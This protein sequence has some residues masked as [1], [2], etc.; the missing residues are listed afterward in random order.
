MDPISSKP[1]LY[2]D[3]EINTSDEKKIY[4]PR[5]WL[6][7]ITPVFKEILTM[8]VIKT[9]QIRITLAYPLKTIHFLLACIT[10]GHLGDVHVKKILEENLTDNLTDNIANNADLGEIKNFLSLCYEYKVDHMKNLCDEVFSTDKYLESFD[11][12]S[13]INMCQIFNMTHIQKNLQK[14]ITKVDYLDYKTMPCS[15]LNFFKE[16]S[17]YSFVE[18]FNLWTIFNNPTDN[19]L[20]NAGL[21]KHNYQELPFCLVGGMLQVLKK[22]SKAHNYKFKILMDLSYVTHPK[23]YVITHPI[24]N[25][26]IGNEVLE[27]FKEKTTSQFSF[28]S[29]DSTKIAITITHDT[30]IYLVQI[31][32]PSDYPTTKTGFATKVVGKLNLEIIDTFREQIKNKT[33][34][35]TELLTDLA[36]MFAEYE[37][38]ITELKN[39]LEPNTSEP[40]TSEPKT[41]KPK[42]TVGPIIAKHIVVL[43]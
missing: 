38:S 32:Y 33:L 15:V 40:N 39:T 27:W 41:S 21:F 35:V 19:E 10:Q 26:T 34:T 9:K 28:V 29:W 43:D 31:N 17:W 37:K 42:N 24:T 22:L 6:M 4:F 16:I 2:S 5:I 3:L 18:T 23:K 20:M 25:R 11:T 14:K 36:T 7:Y 1:T 13:L 12:A 8:N 30:I